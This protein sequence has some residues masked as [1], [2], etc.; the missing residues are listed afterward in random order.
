M[1]GA[2]AASLVSAGTGWAD[3]ARLLPFIVR[4]LIYGAS[5]ASATPAPS[6]S[7]AE[8]SAAAVPVFFM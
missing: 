8:S 2:P 7:S 5:V 6:T 4:T 3:T 1:T